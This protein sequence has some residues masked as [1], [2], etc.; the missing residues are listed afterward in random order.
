MNPVSIIPAF[1]CILIAI[2]TSFL[3]MKQ[4]GAPSLKGRFGSID[5][6]RGYLAFFVFLH[7]SSIWYFYLH[8]GIWA[9]PPSKLYTHFGQS[10][11]AFFFMITGFLFFT[12]L[13]NARERKIDW[14]HLFVS[15]LMRLGPLYFFAMALLF[16]I[17][18]YLS[19]GTLMETPLGIAKSAVRWLSF[20]VLGAPDVNGIANTGII[21]SHVTWSLPYEWFFYLLLP[22]LALTVG[23]RT[24]WWTLIAVGVATAIVGLAFWHP[25]LLNLAT[26]VTGIAAACLVRIEKIRRFSTTL[27]ASIT[28]AMCIVTTVTVFDSAYAVRPLLLLS[29]AFILIASGNTLFGVLTA[30]VSRFFGEQAYSLYLLH[31]IA[32]FVTFNLVIGL[33]T[34]RALTPFF[35]WMIVIVLTPI[36]IITTYCTFHMIEAP[37]MLSTEKVTA[38]LR[39]R[40]VSRSGVAAILKR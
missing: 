10:S 31:G 20:T 37:F 4:F 35:Y 14:L 27:W 40:R 18:F 15:R 32:L 23:I 13:L 16:L 1:V 30:P 5:G 11:V 34:T 21:M 24:P 22:L 9:A 3:L 38:L 19:H 29:V 12:K 6:L 28:V 2:A 26:F 17:A 36:L 39:Q 8:N 25:E 7:H 33:N